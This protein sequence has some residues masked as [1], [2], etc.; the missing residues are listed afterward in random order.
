MEERPFFH[1][2]ATHAD[3]GN[4]EISRVK[5]RGE[6]S[7]WRLGFGRFHHGKNGFPLIGCRAFGKAP[8]KRPLLVFD[9]GPQLIER[10][11]NREHQVKDKCWRVDL[12]LSGFFAMREMETAGASKLWYSEA[13][14]LR[15]SVDTPF[16]VWRSCA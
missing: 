16:N 3:W 15:H 5:N 7:N 9:I 14:F 6:F 2:L 4:G 12:C 8:H 10:L 13:A 1:E 11:P